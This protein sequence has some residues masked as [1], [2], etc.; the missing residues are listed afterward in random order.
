MDGQIDYA[1]ALEEGCADWRLT[2]VKANIEQKLLSALDGVLNVSWLIS[3]FCF[4]LLTVKLVLIRSLFSKSCSKCHGFCFLV[5]RVP[6]PD[7][8]WPSP[9]SLLRTSA[10]LT[11]SNIRRTTEQQVHRTIDLQI[12]RA[13]EPWIYSTTYPQN[14]GFTDPQAH[15]TTDL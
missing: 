1:W 13:K 11:V 4:I 7:P 12:H 15:R 2:K 14:H 3:L 5:W 6:T 8:G 9:E 10:Y